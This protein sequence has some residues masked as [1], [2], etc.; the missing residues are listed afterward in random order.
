M[1]GIAKF[2]SGGVA[3]LLR[4]NNRTASDNAEHSNKEIDAER[5]KFNYFFK[6]GTID[7][8]KARLNEVFSTNRKDKVVLGEVVVTLPTDV[9]PEDERKFFKGV[10]QFYCNDFGSKNIINAVVHCDE[11][12][13]HMHLDFMPV[14]K[15]EVNYKRRYKLVLEEWRKEHNNFE[16]VIERLYWEGIVSRDY[17]KTMHDR[18]S[19]YIAEQLGYEVSIKNGATA[20]GNKT[21]QELK[22]QTL[23]EIVEMQE[24]KLESIN[25]EYELTVKAFEENFGI[26]KQDI[27]LL[28][29]FQKLANLQ[30]INSILEE[31]VCKAGCTF[32]KN[33]IEEIRQLQCL[34]A[35]TEHIS[36]SDERLVDTAIKSPALILIEIRDKD[37]AK[38][39][40][41]QDYIDKNIDLQHYIMEQRTRP[42]VAR[43]SKNSDNIYLIF[44]ADDEDQTLQCILELRNLLIRN[45]D[46]TMTKW[47]E[48][49]YTLYMERL[50]YDDNDVAKAV[51]ESTPYKVVY[52]TGKHK[53]EE[54]EKIT[55]KSKP[56]YAR[57][58]RYDERDL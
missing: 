34:P 13:P 55:Q 52:L 2:K 58:S 27:G 33:E 6:K 35:I 5:T 19:D 32:T 17:L 15:E 10:Y 44:R 54:V 53:Q 42:V 26:R 9:Y 4:H 40:P 37:V 7:N 41:Q 45:A 30:K 18:L 46:D 56:L 38:P 20:Q 51:L 22:S 39:L 36:V 1:A 49:N 50:T 11:T 57:D 14:V 29:L 25:K 48:K 43:P 23:T 24:R 31:T 28:P 3:P 16:P 47:R 12:T 21:V 8:V